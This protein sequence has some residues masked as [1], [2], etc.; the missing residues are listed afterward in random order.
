MEGKS[1]KGEYEKRERNKALAGGRRFPQLAD[2]YHEA[3]FKT[4]KKCI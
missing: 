1:H 2:F 3:Y 4:T